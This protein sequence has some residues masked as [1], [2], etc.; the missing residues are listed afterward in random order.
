MSPSLSAE[1][2]LEIVR[3]Y[4]DSSKD[5]HFTL[6][7]SPEE[8]R[9]QALWTQWIENTGPWSAFR[10]KL[11][12]ELPS[13]VIGETYSSADGGPRCMIYPPKD[14]KTASASWI[15]VG[16]VSLL[17]PVYFVY[18][19]ECVYVEGR[20]RRDKASFGPPHP[21]MVLP[22]QAIA[23]TIETSF[24]FSAVAREIVET[25]VHLFAGM[26]EPPKTNLFHLLFTNAPGIVP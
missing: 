8:N 7:P 19:I 5:F 4:Y 26:L 12:S 24:G 9:R 10:A 11:R 17:A 22:A 14:S 15:V 20:L 25:P 3:N 13:H 1:A 18:G 2:L 6:E 16:C 21:N 23:R